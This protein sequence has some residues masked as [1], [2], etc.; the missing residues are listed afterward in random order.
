MKNCNNSLSTVLVEVLLRG[1]ASVYIVVFVIVISEYSVAV[2]DEGPTISIT[3]LRMLYNNR[4]HLVELYAIINYAK[5]GE[6][7]PYS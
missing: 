3:T 1:T 2:L 4:I 7:L 6:S 5:S